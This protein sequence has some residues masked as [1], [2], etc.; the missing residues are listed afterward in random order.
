MTCVGGCPSSASILHL[1][2][3]FNWVSVTN[4]PE[5]SIIR[6]FYS[7]QRFIELNFT[8]DE[9]VKLSSPPSR[10]DPSAETERDP[11]DGLSLKPSVTITPI[12]N[13]QCH[14]NDTETT[15][16]L[17][18]VCT[19]GIAAA[20]GRRGRSCAASSGALGRIYSH[21]VEYLH[22][23]PRIQ[24]WT[25]SRSPEVLAIGWQLVSETNQLVFGLGVGNQSR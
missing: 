15:P 11:V 5:Q 7:I 12:I 3:A 22:L 4:P 25:V 21:R 16:T 13:F 10:Q 1:R 9:R 23:S 19:A 2:R 18:Q 20:P 24:L 14:S 6:Y 8:L 17:C